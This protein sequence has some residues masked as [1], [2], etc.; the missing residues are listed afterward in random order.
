MDILQ[1]FIG[2][3]IA[4]V[5]LHVIMSVV[6]KDAEKK[7]KGFVFNAYKLSYRRRF[8]RSIWALPFIFLLY[9]AMYW[10]GDLTTNEYIVIGI[11][12]IL[13]ALLDITTSY[14]KWKK[15]EKEA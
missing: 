15:N 3:V 11:I 7:D 9:I 10:F 13:V 1:F 8:I 5:I 12:F 4:I 6:Y 2:P 14:M